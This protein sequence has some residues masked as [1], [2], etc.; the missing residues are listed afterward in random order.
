L[1]EL[2]AAI[3]R[4]KLRYLDEENAKRRE[5]AKLYNELLAGTP[6]CL[7]QVQP[8]AEHVY[9]QYVV[10]TTRRDELHQY[11]RSLGIATHIHYPVPVHLQPA[12][13]GRLGNIGLLPQ[14]ERIAQEILSLPMF[15]E[16][17]IDQV[18]TVA[19]AIIAWYQDIK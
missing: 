1:D 18:H 14:T 6:L 4:V 19:E 9:H 8:D 11:L 10:R 7:P 16:L 13:R 15:A 3:L 5:R 12:Y 2:Q 17:S